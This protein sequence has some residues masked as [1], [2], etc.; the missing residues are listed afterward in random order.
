[1]LAAPVSSGS[2]ES[3]PAASPVSNNSVTP[4]VSGTGTT[5]YVPLWTNTTGGLGNSAIYQGGTASL[6]KV[7]IG[8]ATPAATLD[9]KGSG[10]IRGKLSLP[11]TGVATASTGH[12]SQ[13][14]DW[15]ASV[16]NS[17]SSTPVTETFQWQA[18]PTGNNTAGASGS[19]NLLFGIGSNTPSETGLKIAGDGQQRGILTRQG[20]HFLRE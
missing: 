2:A 19:L 12:D 17:G 8:T 15:A 10:T 5:D 6:P 20:V 11:A 9:V 14:I 7:G 16:F 18:E 3:S 1:V 4:A 13:P